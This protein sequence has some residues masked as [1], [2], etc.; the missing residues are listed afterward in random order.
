VH[1]KTARFPALHKER[2]P[3]FQWFVDHLGDS[4]WE[5]DALSPV[6]VRDRVE[7]AML[8]VIDMDVWNRADQSEQVEIASLNEVLTVWANLRAA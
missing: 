6:T 2:D 5:L 7:E 1:E 8:G 4:C 3:R